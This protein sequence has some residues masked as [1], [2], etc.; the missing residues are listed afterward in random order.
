MGGRGWVVVDGWTWM[1]GRRGWVDG[2]MDGR[3]G[4][5]VDGWWIG[6]NIGVSAS[7]NQRNIYQN[8]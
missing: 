3:R 2:W 1:D 8:I 7:T 6:H 4:W 5:M